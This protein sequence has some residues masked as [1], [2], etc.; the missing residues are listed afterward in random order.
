MMTNSLLKSDNG[1]KT[2]MFSLRRQ[3]LR[4]VITLAFLLL[5]IMIT[6]MTILIHSYQRKVDST[7]GRMCLLMQRQLITACCSLGIPLDT[8][9]PRTAFSRDYIYISLPMTGLIR[10]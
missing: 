6:V 7:S 2:R 9:I 10:L 3:I 1:K 4:F 8:Y 5:L